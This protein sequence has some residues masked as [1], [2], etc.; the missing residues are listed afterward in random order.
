MRYQREVIC[1]RDSYIRS[2]NPETL[3]TPREFVCM[4]DCPSRTVLLLRRRRLGGG[5]FIYD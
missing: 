5:L 3:K 1:C 2:F 4:E